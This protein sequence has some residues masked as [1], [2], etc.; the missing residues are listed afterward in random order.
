[1]TAGAGGWVAATASVRGASH[2]RTGKPNQDAVRVVQ[3]DGPNPGLVAAVCDGHGGERYVRSDVGSRLGVEVA[4]S[5]ARRMLETVGEQPKLAAVEA[6]LTGTVAPAIV[7]RWRERVLAEVERH[8]FTDEERTR[9]GSPL[10]AD[11]FVSYGCTLVLAVLAR[12]WV[13]LLQIGDGD[14]T[15]VRDAHAESPIPGDDRLIGGETTSLCLPTAVADARVAALGL[16]LPETL[17]LTSDGYANSFAST[18]WRTDVGLDLQDHIRRIGMDGVETRLPGWLADSAVAAGDDVSMALLHRRV[19]QQSERAAVAAVGDARQSGGPPAS[20]ERRHGRSLAIAGLAIVVGV[21]GGWA[22]AQSVDDEASPDIISAS[23]T[24]DVAPA[25]TIAPPVVVTQTSEPS[26]DST[27][28][29][30]SPPP[31]TPTRTATVL[32][33]A[34]SDQVVPLTGESGG[35][36]LVFDPNDPTPRARL[37]AWV[38]GNR[39]LDGGWELASGQLTLNGE[40]IDSANVLAAGTAGGVGF[41]ENLWTLSEDCSAVIG[42]RYDG[43]P[44]GNGTITDGSGQ[45]KPAF[46]SPSTAP[47][48]TSDEQNAVQG[49]A[50]DTTPNNS[51]PNGGGS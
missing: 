3:V 35:A 47:G 38:T 34:D 42:Y 44:F 7:D 23:A 36:I 15:V 30:D 26:A 45:G 46:C 32:T 22:L 11:P 14:A 29:G 18:T 37:V 2:E 39:A 27:P 48:P 41:S 10:D 50:D 49:T 17:I 16:P 8:P 24:T 28:E 6:H 19:G 31:A 25:S 21:V 20:R 51:E 33:L 13:G 1:V 12:S 9:A 4:C 43:T 40:P 5:V